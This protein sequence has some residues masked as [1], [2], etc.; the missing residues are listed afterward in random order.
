MLL[1]RLG[2]WVGGGVVCGDAT[3]LKLLRLG[4]GN[5]RRHLQTMEDGIEE[6]EQE[7]MRYTSSDARVA[8][9]T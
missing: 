9:L 6:R 8:T 5:L 1:W 4:H 7:R 3:V 2:L